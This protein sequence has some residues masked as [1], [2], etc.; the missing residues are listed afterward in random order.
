M[1]NYETNKIW[2]KRAV[3]LFEKSISPLPQELNEIDWKTTL[4]DKSER[5]AEHI[6]SFANYSEGGFI[7]FGVNNDGTS[8]GVDQNETSEILK[9]LGNIARQNVEPSIT[10]DH[11]I[12]SINQIPLLFVCIEESSEKPVHLRGKS[13]FESFIRSA[14]QTRKMSK[15]EVARCIA[16]S[17]H[18]PFEDEEATELLQENEISDWVDYISF[19]K[20]LGRSLPQ[21]QDG[22]LDGLLSEKMIKRDGIKFRV[23]N[24]GAILFATDIERF[25]N[26]KRKSVRVG[27]Y[28][29]NDRLQTKK[30]QSG[31]KGYASGFEGL[32]KYINDQLPTN[33]VIRQALREEV[34]VYPEIAIR[35][36]VANALIHQDFLLTGAGPII[37]I[38]SDRIEITNPG[39]PL[40]STMRFIDYP[41]RS[42]NEVL[43]SFMRRI[44]MC[45]ERG[46][47]IDKVVAYSEIFQLPAPDFLGETENYLKAVLYAPKPF[48]EM[49]KKDK[50]RACYQHCCLKYVS[51]EKMSNQTIRDRF[52]ISAQNYPIASR[53]ISDTIKAKL[54]KLLD[55]VSASKKYAYYIPYW[56]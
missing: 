3:A 33:E 35:E 46:S 34:K 7:V 23:T 10:I 6:S 54:I 28:Q 55:P 43:A 12:I 53:I 38:F 41:P 36:L 18:E 44:K 29:S 39:R 20:L 2:E 4:S 27:Q 5:V 15:S 32:I 26:L 40:I 21:T 31:K 42:R 45:E 24:L 50:I 49:D 13:P 9:K 17:S 14:G 19:F 52:K 11:A 37:E 48:S 51:N 1:N 16:T 47:G 22:I 56:A 30:E 8:L 25:D